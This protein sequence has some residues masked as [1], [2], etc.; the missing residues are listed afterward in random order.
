MKDEGGQGILGRIVKDAFFGFQ[1]PPI[2]IHPS[3]LIL[4]PFP[5]SFSVD[6]APN[7]RPYVRFSTNSRPNQL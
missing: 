2:C 5:R 6:T 7:F 1:R 4:H 3:S